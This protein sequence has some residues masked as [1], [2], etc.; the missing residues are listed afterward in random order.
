MSPDHSNQWLAKQ[1]ENSVSEEHHQRAYDEVVRFEEGGEAVL[2]T[3]L[4]MAHVQACI[5]LCVVGSDGPQAILLVLKI[6]EA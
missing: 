1:N 2:L 4:A 5:L 3:D 6:A